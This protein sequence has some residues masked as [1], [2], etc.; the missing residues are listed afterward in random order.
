MLLKVKC[1]YYS[2]WKIPQSNKRHDR[3]KTGFNQPIKGNHGTKEAKPNF[4]PIA[5]K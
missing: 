4:K 3:K 5:I 2:D 1:I